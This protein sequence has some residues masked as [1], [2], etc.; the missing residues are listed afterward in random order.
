MSGLSPAERFLLCT[1]NGDN[2]R[3]R[4]NPEARDHGIAS[5]LLGHLVMTCHI[6]IVDAHIELQ[7]VQ[8]RR[9]PLVGAAFKAHNQLLAMPS[10]T[11]VQR[12]LHLLATSAYEDV[13]RDLVAHKEMH[14]VV[15]H[16]LVG[17]PVTGYVPTTLNVAFWE[18]EFLGDRLEQSDPT[19]GDADILLGA[20][21]RATGLGKQLLRGRDQQ[22][23]DILAS[24]ISGLSSS[25]VELVQHTERVHAKG[26]LSP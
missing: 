26:V 19:L 7:P 1:I 11:Y 23:A 12:W 16:R 24:R 20:L 14:H 10:T 8:P 13:C 21:L 5:A 2:G 25:L 17:P 4:L 18:W 3:E 15:R 6:A 22:V 9:G